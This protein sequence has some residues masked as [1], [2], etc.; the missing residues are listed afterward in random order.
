[1][2]LCCSSAALP[3]LTPWSLKPAML[4]TAPNS[5]TWLSGI[6]VALAAMV[7]LALISR[8]P[9]RWKTAERATLLRAFQCWKRLCEATGSRC[10]NVELESAYD[11]EN[12]QP[13]SHSCGS[14]V[15]ARRTD[16]CRRCR[17]CP[18]R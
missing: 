16:A 6:L 4:P 2:L 13:F 1:M 18:P 12:D 7:T 10:P 14:T 5:A 15:P 3:F 9:E 8:Q 17:R 11:D